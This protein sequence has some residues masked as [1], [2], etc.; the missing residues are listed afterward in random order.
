MKCLCSPEQLG[1]KDMIP[2]SESLSTREYSV[3][4]YS[5][6]AGENEQELDTS[7]IE[8]AESS[9]R[10]SVGLN[11]EEARALLGRLE[12]QRGNIEAALHVFE[13]I[14]IAA[15]TAKIKLSFA[16][17]S[18]KRHPLS[19]ATPPM[20]IHTVSLLLEAIFLKAKSLKDLGRYR[21]AAE[22]CQVILDTVESTLPGGLPEKLAIDCKLQET[23]NKAVE[24]LPE[25]W[26]LAG[27][28]HEAILSYRR[29][30]LHQW[31]LDTETTTKIQKEFAIFLLYSGIDAGPINLLSQVEGTFIPRN[32]MEEAVL[33]LMLLLKK[34]SLGKIEWDPSIIANLS[35]AL[36]V[37]GELK[38]LA[39]QV[40]ELLPGVLD[41]KERY[42]TLALCYYGEGEDLVAL[43]LL[44]NFLR[45]RENTNC[46]HSLLLASKISGEN[47]N[48]AEE[49]VT[50]ARK[51]LAS[52]DGKCNL[53]GNDTN[54]LLGISLSTHAR[55]LLSDSMRTS[56]QNEALKVLETVA[57]MTSYRD[58]K[59]IF[60][61]S[62][63]YAERR[64]LEIAL[65]YAKQSL[66]LDAGSNVRGW[67]LLARILS[68][69]KRFVD[70][71]TIINAALDQTGKW[72][73]GELFRTKAKL[74]I[75]QGKLKNA[76]KTYMNLLAAL[77]GQSTRFRDGKFFLKVSCNH[78]GNLELETWHDLANVYISLSQ[79][80]D[81]EICLSKTKEI[82]P[83]SASRLHMEGLLYEAKGLHKEALKA[84][85]EALDVEP[86]HIP[87]MVSAA[88]VL[89]QFPDK[90]LTILRSLLLTDALRIDRKNSSAWYNLGLLY[91]AKAGASV[92]EAAECFE[93][94]VLLEESSPVEPFR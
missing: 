45:C 7:N 39:N 64:K 79:W 86:T 50:F 61:L 72:D 29:A 92:L 43:N 25:F 28:P 93:A 9:L 52:M 35:F 14:N 88:T 91:K 84:F 56:K 49:G 23:L 40:E 53:V 36:S 33:L 46:I 8:E 80:K 63:E 32:N 59:V 22:S 38:A 71:E 44:R 67:I 42:Y 83:P 3:G 21:E 17:R 51:A 19:D 18:Y 87:S 82:A 68:A 20:S 5:S 34:I 94:A 73:Q 69:Q 78:D 13:G 74:Q 4:G 76:I 81:A 30:L 47:P 37:S 16:G 1:A 27:F 70:A 60:H 24:F 90:S 62:L 11:Y 85:T 10:G 2:S 58:P 12:Y 75:A 89:K 6:Q 48:W 41:M 54:F 65:H 57:R 66:K 15:V 77:Q 26:K 31:N 55:S